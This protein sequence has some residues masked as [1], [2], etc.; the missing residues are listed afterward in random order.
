M[1]ISITGW[2]KG[3]TTSALG[4]IARALANGENVLF[5]QFLKGGNDSALKLFNTVDGFKYK[6]QGCKLYHETDATSFYDELVEDIKSG[7]YSLVVLDELLVALDRGFIS[8][9]KER[10]LTELSNLAINTDIYLTERVY[11]HQL[12]H[13]VFRVSD[14]ASN[15]FAEKHHYNKVCTECN[16]EYPDEFYYCPVCRTKLTRKQQAKLG[17]EY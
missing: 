4:I 16:K 17:R 11:N 10:V 3:K 5:A 8:H 15:C 7:K 2:G 9:T 6:N 14:I 13:D 1:L 12:R